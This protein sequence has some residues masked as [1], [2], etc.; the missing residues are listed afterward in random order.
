MDQGGERCWLETLD[1]LG[2]LGIAGA[3]GAIGRP[4]LVAEDL[5]DGLGDRIRVMA[6]DLACGCR[7]CL[8]IADRDQL[9]PGL[10]MA[11]RDVILPALRGSEDAQLGEGLALTAGQLA[12]RSEE[13]TSE[14]Q[15][16]M[17]NSYAVFCLK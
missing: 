1:R 11:D 5:R 8:R 2:E 12:A 13:H 9:Q 16:L 3:G 15:S 10:E 14:L 17:R 4:D 7:R 6:E